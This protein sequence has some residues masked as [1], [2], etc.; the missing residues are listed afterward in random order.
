M[1]PTAGLAP[2][3][4]R[5]LTV[6]GLKPPP[7]PLGQ[8]RRSWHRGRDSNSRTQTQEV[9]HRPTG[10]GIIWQPRPDSNRQVWV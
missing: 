9:L 1:V 5:T 10:L 7:L 3:G 4:I 2:A 8:A 6:R